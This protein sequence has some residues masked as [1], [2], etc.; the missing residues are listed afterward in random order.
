MAKPFNGFMNPETELM[1]DYL[2]TDAKESTMARVADAWDATTPG[3]EMRDKRAYFLLED[4]LKAEYETAL[5]KIPS[6]Y[7][8]LLQSAIGRVSWTEIAMQLVA[9][10]A[11]TK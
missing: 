6:P 1:A 5:P 4:R 3:Q 7:A 11:K 9:D 2:L 8:D 10:F